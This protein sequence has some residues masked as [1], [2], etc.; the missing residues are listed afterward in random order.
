MSLNNKQRDLCRGIADAVS[1]QQTADLTNANIRA[2]ASVQDCKEL[3]EQIT[4][5]QSQIKQLQGQ[6]V[7]G[8]KL[9]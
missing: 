6:L 5:L 4:E 7:G 8:N 2:D 3:Q 9:R 1:D